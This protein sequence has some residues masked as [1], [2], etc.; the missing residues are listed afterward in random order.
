MLASAAFCR[1]CAHGRGSRL[2]DIFPRPGPRMRI[3]TLS[4]VLLSLAFAG[5][6]HAQSAATEAITLDR[7]RVHGQRP[8]TVA[9]PAQARE[10]LAQRAGR[11]P[12][13]TA[14]PTAAAA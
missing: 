3:V 4:P 6:A 1:I 13:S 8:A 7:L 5:A 11:P 9:A 14:S 12:G 10:R 2:A